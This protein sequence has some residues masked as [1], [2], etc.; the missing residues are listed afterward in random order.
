MKRWFVR[1]WAATTLALAAG[2]C[3]SSGNARVT[4]PAGASMRLAA[5]SLE[6][7]GVIG[8]AKLFRL[9][10]KLTGR[11]RSIKAGTYILN[12]AASWN[13]VVNDLVAGTATV[14]VPT[15]RRL[16]TTGV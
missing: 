2:G 4:V 16:T 9:Y 5:D 11:D 3:D 15:Y 10:A 12:R 14:T 6:A 13:E 8:S 7:A 1:L